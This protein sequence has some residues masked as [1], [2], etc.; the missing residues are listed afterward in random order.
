MLQSQYIDQVD[1]QCFNILGRYSY[2]RDRD[3]MIFNVSLGRNSSK[4][5]WLIQKKNLHD[6]MKIYACNLVSLSLK[7]ILIAKATV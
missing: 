2:W 3:C 7:F 5:H 1:I 6:F 4:I